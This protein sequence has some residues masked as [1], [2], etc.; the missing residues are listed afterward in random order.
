MGEWIPEAAQPQPEFRIA[1]VLLIYENRPA[2]MD[3]LE[4]LSSDLAALRSNLAA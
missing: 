3:V 1:V 4:S 2:R